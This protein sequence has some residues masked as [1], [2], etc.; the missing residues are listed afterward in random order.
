MRVDGKA[1]SS[2]RN[3]IRARH[4]GRGKLGSPAK[5]T[6]EWLS[7][8][9]G[10]SLRAIQQLE[11]SNEAS[12]RTVKSV[13]RVLNI[14]H[15]EEYLLDYGLEYLSCTTK[16]FVDFRPEQN[17]DQYPDTYMNSTLMLTIDPL[18]I[19]AESGKFDSF[20][21]KE[22]NATISGLD[23]FIHC[24]W[25]A[26][27]SLTPGMNGWLGWVKET[28]EMQIEAVDKPL[29]M[30]I[31]FK[32]DDVPHASWADFIELV[33]KNQMSQFDIEVQL[34]FV[35]FDKNF[36]VHISTDLLKILFEKGREKYA[37]AWPHRA[38]IRAIV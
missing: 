33:E 38:Q 36:K 20:F 31:M 28:E 34:R 8:E 12:P 17:P 7:E 18:S 29:N 19:L 22:V 15:W 4:P 26:E 23:R 2:A 16:G 35:R 3:K 30:S 10:V 9:A 5:G 14:D 13:S 21:L 37:S 32:Q 1:F 24:S 11:Q 6:Q 25:L 27:V